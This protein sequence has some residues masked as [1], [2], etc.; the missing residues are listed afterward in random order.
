M[1]NVVSAPVLHADHV[2]NL[3]GPS[4]R[5]ILS[6]ANLVAGVCSHPTNCLTPSDVHLRYMTE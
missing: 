4:F 6:G 5:A 3:L 1:L 2:V